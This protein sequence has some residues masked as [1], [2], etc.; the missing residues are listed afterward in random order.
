[1][2][3][4]NNYSIIQIIMKNM[5][6][7]QL[8]SLNHFNAINLSSSPSS[9]SLWNNFTKPSVRLS[10]AFSSAVLWTANTDIVASYVFLTIPHKFHLSISHTCSQTMQKEHTKNCYLQQ[11]PKKYIYIVILFYP[12][13]T[14][15][16]GGKTTVLPICHF[17]DIFVMSY[18]AKMTTTM[19]LKNRF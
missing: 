4:L 12:K 1:M 14:Q 10:D 6:T 2:Q 7:S 19:Q 16:N 9:V 17:L 11:L 8:N 18:P 15:K 13:W 5:L 3:H